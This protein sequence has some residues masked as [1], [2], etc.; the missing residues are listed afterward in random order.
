MGNGCMIQINK[1]QMICFPCV[2]NRL[3]TQQF[4]LDPKSWDL[5]IILPFFHGARGDVHYFPFIQ[6]IITC[7]CGSQ[8][9]CGKFLI[10][11]K[12]KQL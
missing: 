9:Q 6:F 7:G 1:I 10:F 8:L 2:P 3:G 11:G 4:L 5:F 12:G